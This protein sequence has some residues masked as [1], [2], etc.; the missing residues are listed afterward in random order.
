MHVHSPCFIVHWL[1]V[2]LLVYLI[3]S[4]LIKFPKSQ[5]QLSTA[6]TLSNRYILRQYIECWLLV[7]LLVSGTF[8]QIK[9]VMLT[10]SQQIY[11]WEAK[12]LTNQQ[13]A[14][15]Y[16]ENKLTISKPMNHF[17]L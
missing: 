3:C 17:G 15:L 2:N 5:L 4:K 7:K 13:I 6:C 12:G 10:K 14:L 8:K 11:L 1:L 9:P 16:T